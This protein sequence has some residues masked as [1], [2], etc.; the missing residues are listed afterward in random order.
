MNTNI[1][2]TGLLAASAIWAIS[3][4]AAYAEDPQETAAQIAPSGNG[5]TRPL[6]L[7][8]ADT[9]DRSVQLA[10]L[11]AEHVTVSARRVDEDIQKVPL[12][13]SVV[14]DQVVA[15]TGAYNLER[16]TQILPSLQFFSQNP[17]AASARR[18][19]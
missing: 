15:N 12:A 7:A 4:T 16:L 19:A 13:V 5:E 8:Q 2:R 6:V 11:G 10:Q 18:W 3:G 9:S 14:S 1:L 17:R